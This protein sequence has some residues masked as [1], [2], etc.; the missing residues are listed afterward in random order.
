[1]LKTGGP[2]CT[3]YMTVTG[4]AVIVLTDEGLPRISTV[5]IVV[6]TGSVVAMTAPSVVVM[7]LV[8]VEVV[9]LPDP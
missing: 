1:M 8:L 3:V 7:R 4:A 6:G 9:M 2:L 5:A